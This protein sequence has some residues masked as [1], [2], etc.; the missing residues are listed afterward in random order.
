MPSRGS[1]VAASFPRKWCKR[2]SGKPKTTSSSSR[3]GACWRPTASPCCSEPTDLERMA[4]DRAEIISTLSASVAEQL[5]DQ[6]WDTYGEVVVFLERS[7]ALHTGQFRTRSRV[8]PDAS[9]RDAT[10]ST[11][12]R[13]STHEPATGPPRG[14]R[15]VRLRPRRPRRVRAADV[16]PAQLRPAPGGVRAA[17][18]GARRP[19]R[20]ATR[21]RAAR[22]TAS[23]VATRSSRA[24]A[25]QGYDQQGYGQQGY[26][27]QGYEQ[28]GQPGL[29]PAGLRPAAAGLRPAGLRPAGLRAARLRPAGL[30][31]GLR[32]AGLRPAG[33][34][35][36][37]RPG[38]RRGLPAG[39]RPAGV[40]P[41]GLRA[42]GLRAAGLRQ[43]AAHRHPARW[44][45]AP[46]APTTSPRAPT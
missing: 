24:T 35:A 31:P 21:R 42:A 1:S 9:R 33:L 25:S 13:R 29:R 32:P 19:R 44:T 39:L 26:G 34:R 6:G 46:G 17:A 10:P 38:L 7:D 43:P 8:D 3:A 41:A 15:A 22:A 28:G 12:R 14:E 36:A 4:G 18:A 23:R 2:C 16:C 27:Q 20:A 5:A 40:R 45:T 37:V 30:R 11:R